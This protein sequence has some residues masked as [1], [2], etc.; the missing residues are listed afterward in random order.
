MTIVIKSNAFPANGKIPE[1]YTCDGV[2]ISPPLEWSEVPGST[3][4]VALLMENPD[5]PGR[6][7]VHWMLFNVPP[8]IREL[9]EGIPKIPTLT[10]YPWLAYM[11]S[12]GRN[13]YGKPG[14]GGPCPPR[15]EKHRYYFRVYALD[16]VLDIPPMASKDEFRQAVE[17]HVIGEGELMGVYKR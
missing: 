17:G 2:G 11:G 10:T 7:F 1:K 16:R 9:P 12:Q 3:I 5:A 15:G 6:P 8:H 13:D 14:Y 4:T